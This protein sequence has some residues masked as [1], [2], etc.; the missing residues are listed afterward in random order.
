LRIFVFEFVTGGGLAGRPVP[1]SLA[2]EGLAMR[3]ALL[4]DLAAIGDHAIVA[5]TDVRFAHGAPRGVD[6]VPIVSVAG[7]LH[8]STGARGALSEVE[9]QAFRQVDALVDAADA[10]WLIAP[11]TDRCLERLASRIERRGTRLLGSGAAAIRIAADKS[12]L[13]RRLAGVGLHHPETSS[14]ASG[15]DARMAARRLGYPV[16]VKPARGAGG[17]GVRLA[18]H[19]SEL[20]VAVDAAYRANSISG[21]GRRTSNS[22]G[23]P[24][25]MQRFVRGRA[26]SVSLVADGHRAVPLA[27]NE[28]RITAAAAFRYGGGSTPL[29]HPQAAAAAD[30]AAQ[31]CAAIPGLHG[32]VG[33]DLVLTDTGPI[34]IEVNPRLTLAYLGLRVTVDE[35]VAALAMAACE[36]RLPAP[37]T[38]RRRTHFTASGRIVSR[39][40]PA[41]SVGRL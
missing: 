19:E 11:E 8:S 7:G 14:I 15:K 34:V 20:A 12:R 23:G 36:G 4:E 24:L 6:L 40:R 1:R 21:L 10:V 33:V 38:P 35:N 25:V 2:R 27:V 29:D 31:T 5:S 3:T 37:L 39:L 13:P 32:Y 41:A 17:H 30:A 28:Q 18:R 26:A 9:G 16:V 22:E